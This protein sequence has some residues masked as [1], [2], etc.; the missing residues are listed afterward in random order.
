MSAGKDEL[1]VKVKDAD[2]IYVSEMIS[3]F[4]DGQPFEQLVITLKQIITKSLDG[5]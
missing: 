4:D 3:T 2:D 1:K 5:S